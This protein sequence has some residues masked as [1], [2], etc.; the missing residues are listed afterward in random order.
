VTGKQRGADVFAQFH[1]MQ[2]NGVAMTDARTTP[3]GTVRVGGAAYVTVSP[4]AAGAPLALTVKAD[5]GLLPRV[6]VGRLR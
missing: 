5:P 2:M 6:R 3:A 4:A 1:G